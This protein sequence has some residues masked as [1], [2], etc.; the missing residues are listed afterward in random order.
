MCP[1]LRGAPWRPRFCRT[2]FTSDT[3]AEPVWS[4]GRMG[5]NGNRELL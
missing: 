5:S 2:L 4:N 3:M 1:H